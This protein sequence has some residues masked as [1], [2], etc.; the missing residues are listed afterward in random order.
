VNGNFSSPG[1][2]PVCGAGRVRCARKASGQ[3]QLLACGLQQPGQPVQRRVFRKRKSCGV[4]R[5]HAMATGAAPHQTRRSRWGTSA[6]VPPE[7]ERVS[8]HRSNSGAA[9]GRFNVHVVLA[10]RDALDLIDTI[11]GVWVRADVRSIR[12]Q[13]SGLSLV[14][15]AR[16]GLRDAPRDVSGRNRTRPAEEFDPASRAVAGYVRPLLSGAV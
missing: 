13:P 14:E 2:R 10:W 9:G 12:R 6:P 11:F 8:H 7:C 4:A 1:F 5:D 16:R 15:R 3:S